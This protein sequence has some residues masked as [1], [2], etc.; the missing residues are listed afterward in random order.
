VRK[1]KRIKILFD[2]V[3]LASTTKSGV[4]KSVEGIVLALAHTYP[5]EVELVGHYFNF[6]GRKEGYDLPSAPNIRYRKTVLLPG[7]IFNMLRRLHIPV[8]YELL[9]KERGDFHLFLAFLGWPS[10]FHTPYAVFA[11][12]VTYLLHPEFVSSKM[13]SDLVRFMPKT[14]R[15]ATFI[16]TNSASSQQGLMEA[17]GL[18]K[19]IF[20]PISLPPVSVQNLST[21]HTW[22]IPPFPCHF[23]A[24]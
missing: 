24:T 8:P 12:D 3:P 13:R 19:E 15:R 1:N 22:R 20:L 7:K 10:S 9:V 2:A 18:D 5:N 16:I 23:R 4:G 11:H 21:R 14:L 17:Y 6:L